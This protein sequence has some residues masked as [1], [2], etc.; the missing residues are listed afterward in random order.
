MSTTTNSKSMSLWVG[1]GLF[2]GVALWLIFDNLIYLPIGL[3]VGI[4]IGSVE[5]SRRG[6]RD[7]A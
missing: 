6:R 5:A 2:F 4:V 1:I 7:R 3:L